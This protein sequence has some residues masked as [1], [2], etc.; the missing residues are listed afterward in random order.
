MTTPRIPWEGSDRSSRLPSNW[1]QLRRIVE[2]RAGGRCEDM[3]DGRRCTEPGTDCDHV[4][5]GD[6]HRLENLQWMCRFHHLRKTQSENTKRKPRQKREP[7]R[8]PGLA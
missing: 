1:Q 7:E 8:H 6:D 5:P 3:S 4:I 2:Q